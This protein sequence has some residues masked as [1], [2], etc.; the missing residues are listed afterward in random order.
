MQNRSAAGWATRMAVPAPATR[1]GHG[2]AWHI[3]A[4]TKCC[5]FKGEHA[6]HGP[7]FDATCSQVTLRG[8][9]DNC[10]GA[11]TELNSDLTLTKR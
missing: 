3:Q 1:V 10:T 2:T 11:R 4:R 6:A 8:Y 7:T 5:K 9:I